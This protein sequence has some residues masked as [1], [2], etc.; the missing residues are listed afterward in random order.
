MCSPYNAYRVPREGFWLPSTYYAESVAVLYHEGM[1]EPGA[2][3]TGF[4]SCAHE[5]IRS[6][7]LPALTGGF[8]T[9]APSRGVGFVYGGGRDTILVI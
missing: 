2:A 5:R 9:K 8:P 1:S 6:L 3:A 4:F 7:L